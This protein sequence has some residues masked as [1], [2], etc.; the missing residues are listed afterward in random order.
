MSKLLKDEELTLSSLLI[1]KMASHMNTNANL[2]KR[3]IR[4]NL[5]KV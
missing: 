2:I 5:F 4:T 3:I 1:D